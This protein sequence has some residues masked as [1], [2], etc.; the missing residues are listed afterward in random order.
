MEWEGLAL[1][2]L[3]LPLPITSG[4]VIEPLCWDN[5]EAYATAMAGGTD[6]PYRAKLLSQAHRFL[7]RSPQEVQIDVARLDGEIAGYS[8]LRL[9][10]NGLAYLRNVMRCLL[11]ATVACIC[12][13]WLIALL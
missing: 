12:R 3:S 8:V 7:Q 1:D 13:S 11:S 10:P 4:L 9:E 2:D 5:A 6:S